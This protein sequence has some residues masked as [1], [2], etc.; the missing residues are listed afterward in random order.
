M[1]A[2]YLIDTNVVSKY[3]DE[4]LPEWALVLLDEALE[5]EPAQLS[6]I[7][8]IELKVYRPLL[9]QREQQI[10]AFIEASTVLPLSEPIIQQTIKLRRH[11]KGLKLPD[12]IIAATAMVNDFTLP[13]TNNIDFQRIT[14]LKYKS[15]SN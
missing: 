5:K 10:Q 2:T 9:I 1:G 6:V 14:N 4:A 7:T 12:A 15:L 8:R 13:S 3:F 11:Y